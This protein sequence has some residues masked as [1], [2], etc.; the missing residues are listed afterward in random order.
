MLFLTRTK[1]KLR[2]R[3]LEDESLYEQLLTYAAVKK[4]VGGTTASLR[5]I[6]K[7]KND[8]NEVIPD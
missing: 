4:G 8:R 3:D 7:T 5:R 2:W 1:R 6:P